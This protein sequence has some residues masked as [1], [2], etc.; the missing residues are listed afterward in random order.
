[1]PAGSATSARESIGQ[2]KAD[3]RSRRASTTTSGCGPAPMKP[4]HRNQFHYDWHWF[5]DYGNG[6]IGNQGVHQM[7][8]ARWGLGKQE[9]PKRV[10]SLG[11]RFGYKDDGRDAQHRSSP[12]STTTTAS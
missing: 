5:W 9:L 8:I 1:M 10:Q 7:D 12:S 3:S 2:V 6:D 11:G 4:I